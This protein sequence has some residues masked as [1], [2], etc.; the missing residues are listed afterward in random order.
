MHQSESTML[1]PSLRKFPRTAVL[2]GIGEM[3]QPARR[4]VEKS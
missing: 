1:A 2:W 4:K 3:K